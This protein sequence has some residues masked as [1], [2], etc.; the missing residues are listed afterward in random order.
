LRTLTED[1]MTTG[2]GNGNGTIHSRALLVWLTIS[3]WSARKYD[4]RI[5]L[6]TNH[7]LGASSDAGRYNKLLLPGDAKSYKALVSLAGS[8]RAQ[9]YSNTLT[10]SDEGWR[11]LPVDNYMAYT[12]WYRQ[13]QQA[14]SIAL[15]DFL[16]DY[17]A[18]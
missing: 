18:M 17:P 6:D 5:T 2:N 13:Q 9:H 1:R 4:K 10:W 15:S 16:R 3:L 8:I 11:L 7:R 14:L 12:Q